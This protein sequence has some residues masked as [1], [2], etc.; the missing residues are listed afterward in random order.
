VAAVVVAGVDN[1]ELREPA[2]TMRTSGRYAVPIVFMAS[3]MGFKKPD[4][5]I[6]VDLKNG[7][8]PTTIPRID[9]TTGGLNILVPNS[10]I[11]SP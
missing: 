11:F 9:P 3:K 4:G 1:E 6:N 10:R 2:S 7:M 5:D 8:K